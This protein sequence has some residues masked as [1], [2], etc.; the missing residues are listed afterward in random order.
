MT[1]YP[2]AHCLCDVAAE[3]LS[4]APR[5]ANIRYGAPDCIGTFMLD[6]N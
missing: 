1:V 5:H 6:N 4:G 2:Q 3:R